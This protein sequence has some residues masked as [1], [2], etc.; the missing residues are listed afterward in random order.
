MN[1][2]I[3]LRS[4]RRRIVLM[5]LASAFLIWQVPGMDFLGN[6]VVENRPVAAAIAGGG[7]VVWAA[8]LIYLFAA[9]RI[10][11]RRGDPG[12]ASALE[13]ELVQSNRARAFS[14]GYWVT[15]L[16][17]A[18]LF[19][20]SLFQPVG[21]NEAAHLILVVAVVTPIYAFVVLERSNA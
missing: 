14:A 1:D 7:F 5:I 6:A 10:A 15:L 18:A 12:V 20:L 4:H 17:A 19:L 2:E 11:S 21:G 9:G 3:E 13:D 16:A 8:A